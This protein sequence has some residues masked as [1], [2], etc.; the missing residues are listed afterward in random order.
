MYLRFAYR[1]V[2]FAYLRIEGCISIFLRIGPA[3]LRICVSRICVLR[4]AYLRSAFAYLRFAYR[5]AAKFMTGVHVCVRMLSL[6][7]VNRG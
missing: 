5:R 3:Y 7:T 6:E 1:G 4:F 2:A